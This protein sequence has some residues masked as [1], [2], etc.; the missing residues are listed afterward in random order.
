VKLAALLFAWEKGSQEIKVWLNGGEESA[1]YNQRFSAWT[2]T[3]WLD[4][5]GLNSA[6]PFAVTAVKNHDTAGLSF[7]GH[8]T[9]RLR[10]LAEASRKFWARYDPDDP[11][12]APTN[13]EVIRWIT[14]QGV[15]AHLAKVM[16][17]ILRANGLPT[18]R[19]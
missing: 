6:F 11:S 2:L 1:F 13:D 14:A 7:G 17:T 9:R 5:I 4:S 3:T 10:I 16:A 18:G 15:S 8:E 19:R 12:T